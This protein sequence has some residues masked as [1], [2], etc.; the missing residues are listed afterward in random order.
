M[1]TSVDPPSS[2]V[3]FRRSQVPYSDKWSIDWADACERGL[4]KKARCE[5]MG[6]A[7]SPHSCAVANYCD[8]LRR[9]LRYGTSESGVKGDRDGEEDST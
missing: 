8:I 5:T 1:V 2:R 3:S 6:R 9:I 7:D 4:W